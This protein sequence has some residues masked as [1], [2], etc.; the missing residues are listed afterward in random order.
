M[1]PNIR[2]MY[3]KRTILDICFLLL[4]RRFPV[5]KYLEQAN[6]LLVGSESQLT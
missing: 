5:S 1:T 6:H 3:Y 2:H 4:L